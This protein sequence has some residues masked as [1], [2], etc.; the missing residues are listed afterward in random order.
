MKVNLFL[1]NPNFKGI[2]EDRNTVSQL[3]ENNNYSLT[4]PN[5][6]RINKAIEN[7]AKQ[8]GEENI[9]FLLDVGENLKYQAK[10]PDKTIKTKN[11]WS[12]KLKGAAEESLAHSNPILKDKYQAKIDAVFSEK[13]LSKDEEDMAKIKNRLV[14]K[15]KGTEEEASVKKNLE[16]FIASTETPIEQKK[17]V[18][19]RLDYFM[20]PKYKINPQL[21]DKK[22]KVLSEI[23]NDIAINTLDTDIPNTK[24]VNQKTHGMCAA[25]AIVRK[26]VA[27]ED[28]P[29][30]VDAILSELDDSDTVKIYDKQNLGSG[31]RIPVKKTYVDFNYAQERGYRIID[32]STLQ[33]MNIAG[34]YGAQNEGLQEFNAFDKNNFDAFHDSFFSKNMADKKLM[35]KQVYYQALTKAEEDIKTVKSSEIKRD[36]EATV[37]RQERGT[38]IKKLE[39]SNKWLRKTI[40]DVAPVADKQSRAMML[41]D[42]MKLSQPL[43]S[44]LNKLPAELKKYAFLPNEEPEQK[45][46]KIEA[47]FGENYGKTLVNKELV[48]ENSEK[49]ADTLEEMR[50]TSNKLN[51]SESLSK[52]IARARKL[53]E[54]EAIFRA[55][56]VVGLM[57][58]DNKT[59][60]LIQNN[61]PDRETR[62]SKG[63]EEAIDRIKNKNDKK[64][65]EHFAPYFDTTPEDKDTILDGLVQI[66][67]VID[68]MTTDGLDQIYAQMGFGNRHDILIND[69]E[70]CIESIKKGD[71]D[72]LKR[73]GTCLHVKNKEDK[74]AVLNKLEKLKSGIEENPQDQEKYIEAFNK[75]GYKDQVDAFVDLFNHFSKNINAESPLREVYVEGF[76]NANNLKEDAKEEEI[77]GILQ[78]IGENFNYISETIARAGNMLEID[79]EDGTPYFTTNATYL[80][81]NSLE[82]DGELVP[83]K[84]M[85]KLQERFAK[86]DKIRSSDEFSSRQGKISDPSLYKL[87]HEEKEAIKQIDKKLNKMYAFVV[88]ER[89]NVF[90]EIKPELEELAK[91]I[92]TNSGSYWMVKDGSSGL[93]EEQQVKIFEEITDRPHYKEKDIDKAVDKIKNSE[94]SGISSSHVFHDKYGGHAMYV[95]DIVKDEKTG[96]DIL[97]HDNSWGA[98]EHENTWV[99]SEGLTRTDYSDHRGGELGYITNKDWRNGNFVENLTHKKGHISPDSTES[100]L[101]RKLNPT[102]SDEND[103]ALMS[104]I[105]L[106]GTTPEYRDVAG[107][108]K[109]E[110]F[111]PDSTYIKTL[112]KHANNMTKKE[113]QKAIFK[114]NSMRDSYKRNY[115]NIIKRITHTQFNKGIQTE[116]DYNALP[117]NDPI[118]LAFE[119]AAIRDSFEDATM[120]KELGKAKT[121]DAVIKIKEKQRQR[122]LNDFYYAFGK[123]GATDNC[124]L[125]AAYNNGMDFSNAIMDA[126]KKYDIKVTSEQGGKIVHNVCLLEKDEQPLYNGSIKNNID[127]FLK[128]AEKQFDETIPECENKESAKAEYLSNL[129]KA[130]EKNIYFN[131]EDLKQDTAKAKGIRMWIDDKFEPKTDEEFVSI[132]RMLQDMPLEEFKKYTTDLDDKYLGMKEETGYDILTKVQN[133][134]HSAEMLLR[135]TVYYD[136]YADTFDLSKTKD[137][138]KY[139]KLER[140]TRGA[141]YVGVRTFDDLY[142]S[143]NYSLETLEYERL[144][145]QYKDENYRKW[146]ALPAYPKIDLDEDPALNKKLETTGNLVTE[147]FNTISIQKNC[148]YDI[149]LA[150]MMDEYRNSIPKDRPLT[151]I[152]RKVLTKM[153]QDFIDANITDTDMEDSIKD[154]Q[155]LLE[156]DKNATIEDYNEYIDTIIDTVS[157]I[158]NVNGIEDFQESI[159]AHTSALKNYFNTILDTNIPPKYHR[160]LKEDVK[161]WMALERAERKFDNG[162]DKNKNLIDLQYKISTFAKT[163]NKK[164]MIE[165]FVKISDTLDKIKESNIK[166]DIPKENVQFQIMSLDKLSDKYIDKFI[167]PEGRETIKSTLND[168]YQK[169]LLGGH[170]RMVSEDEIYK[171]RAKFEADFRKHHV[172]SHPTEILDNFILLSAKDAE[173]KKEQNNY[174]QYLEIEL[175][176]AKF[177]SI[178]DALMEAVS[179]GNASRVKEYFD[180]YAVDP[181]NTGDTVSMNSDVAI[182]YMV[183]NMLLDHN[184]E[185]AK[186]FVEKLGLGE[187]VMKIERKTIEELDGKAQV[188][189]MAK[190]LKE[191]S[192]FINTAKAEYQKLYDNIDNIESRE[193]LDKAILETRKNLSK[194]LKYSD[195]KKSIKRIMEPLTE[196]KEILDEKPD[197]TKSVILNSRVNQAVSD[198]NDDYNDRI[199][200]AQDY[201]NI[202]NLI[203][204]FLKNIQLPEH[205]N[206]QKLQDKIAKEHDAFTEYNNKVILAAAQENPNATLRQRAY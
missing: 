141:H 11:D 48:A 33:W 107:S 196:I 183:R 99:D 78:Q 164:S 125:A 193:E 154:A 75:M 120:Y 89:N 127:I 165:G 92:G 84:T 166:Q 192:K 13:P 97:Y 190:V 182:D 55:S 16:Y 59:D 101:Y 2:R 94:H 144:F 95:A 162:I 187:R 74:N 15:V 137:A 90:K 176:L 122:A 157:L 189:Y 85:K 52:Q 76:K 134:N 161:N 17:Y 135:N 93:Y 70:D 132:Y 198:L 27:Y 8:R 171:A 114:Q 201:I 1:Q 116:A 204:S 142:R 38:N 169:E 105:I 77:L 194:A 191:S 6:R 54:S 150:H 4:E 168:W 175:N 148:I 3:K 113:I 160:I 153:T 200:D 69:M 177:I 30:F 37:N 111:I 202:I 152:E 147:A 109:D 197:I 43:S 149:K 58:N 31:K 96:K 163:D 98:S 35:Q 167:K 174:K 18:M 88:R 199:K 51:N 178:Q 20:S 146:G 40:N 126:L 32:A 21:A 112:E 106:E 133:A 24:A 102:A 63:Y 64:M 82:K 110:I 103:F 131:K 46:K 42:L 140:N 159:D 7:L 61:I 36:L 41:E 34:M 145:N 26:A 86:I 60:I 57:E 115:D 158:E 83:A 79:N 121:M 188:D 185:T 50:E 14:R 119:K 139:R 117:D 180:E 181:Y 12:N 156:L 72:E 172:T 91:Y 124:F 81:T 205:S 44:E 151:S 47:Y 62:I 66:K 5:Q 206:A 39:D 56:I 23:A 71:K 179:A 136:E 29:N 25:I 49:I 80:V 10:L 143:F 100:K 65:L 108:I 22:E 45:Q 173:K 184:P 138:Y 155:E 186:M 9:K 170:T 53:Y 19:K 123:N 130:Y 87:S 129:Q 128:R 118:K 73:A 195:D 104:G 68:Y 67:S 28:K 203:Y